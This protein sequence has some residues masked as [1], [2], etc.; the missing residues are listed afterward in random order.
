MEEWK[1]MNF[2][3]LCMYATTGRT[4]SKCMTYRWHMYYMG[5]HC[6]YASG[7]YFPN[8]ASLENK[9]AHYANVGKSSYS[10]FIQFRNTIKR[11][12][13]WPYNKLSGQHC[14]LIRP[15][16]NQSC[17]NTNKVVPLDWTRLPPNI[18]GLNPKYQA[19]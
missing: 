6:F 14:C 10:C 5:D 11:R 13:K 8:F 17:M 9:F 2:N 15:C 1:F 18:V 16:N 12:R 7:N 4:Y 19:R 3:R